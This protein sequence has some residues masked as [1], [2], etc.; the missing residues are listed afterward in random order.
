MDDVKSVSKRPVAKGQKIVYPDNGNLNAVVWNK[1]S[2]KSRTKRIS[3][4]RRRIATNGSQRNHEKRKKHRERGNQGREEGWDGWKGGGRRQRGRGWVAKR[5]KRRLDYTSPAAWSLF[6]RNRF[7]ITK[8]L[9]G[10]IPNCT[11]AATLVK[12]I[13]ISRT[14]EHWN[15]GMTH[16]WSPLNTYINFPITACNFRQMRN[17]GTWTSSAVH[18]KS[19]ICKNKLC[20]RSNAR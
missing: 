3:V 7:F 16:N 14:H 4:Y 12:L 8:S 9:T 13:E 1:R 17:K 15:C 5:Q 20:I 6:G 18:V 19:S 11:F 10:F 2:R